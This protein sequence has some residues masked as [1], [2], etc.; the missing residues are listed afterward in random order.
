MRVVG[1]RWGKEGVGEEAV[2]EK[3]AFEDEVR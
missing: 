3:G 2:V 1:R